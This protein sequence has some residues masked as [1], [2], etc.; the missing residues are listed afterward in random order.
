M[1][2]GITK[3]IIGNTSVTEKYEM[4]SYDDIL[5]ITSATITLAVPGDIFTN[6]GNDTVFIVDS[7]IS[8]ENSCALYLG[9]GNDIL[10]IQNSTLNTEI[11]AGSGSDTVSIV[12]NAQSYVNINNN[13]NLGEGD[14]I[15]EVASSL[16]GTGNLVFGN[17]YD[18][19]RFNGGILSLSGNIM[20]LENIETTADGGSIACDLYFDGN[21][22]NV[23]LAGNINGTTNQRKLFWSNATI[24]LTTGSNISTNVA[25]DISNSTLDHTDG[26]SLEFK[27]VGNYAITAD[28]S[29]IS[30]H[31]VTFSQSGTGGIFANGVTLSLTHAGFSN[32]QI[33]ISQTDGTL[34][35]E[36][37]SLTNHSLQALDLQ[38]TDLTGA[39][40]SFSGNQIAIQTNADIN[41]TSAKIN[42]NATGVCQS[43]GNGTFISAGLSQNTAGAIHHTGGTLYLVSGKA[44]KNTANCSSN[45]TVKTSFDGYSSHCTG[46]IYEYA[47][48]GV[49]QKNGGTLILT[50]I[51]LNNNSANVKTDLFLSSNIYYNTY[52]T[53]YSYVVGYTS[54]WDTW[55]YYS[56]KNTTY[57]TSSFVTRPVYRNGSSTY[58]TCM[59]R[60]FS[61]FAFGGAGYQNGGEC[62]IQDAT[63]AQ[64]TAVANITRS[65]TT[66]GTG[67]AKAYGGAFY[68][69]GQQ[70][71]VTSATFTE[72]T[73]RTCL[74]MV[75]PATRTVRTRVGPSPRQ[76]MKRIS[77]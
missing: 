59:I 28:N 50:D 15:L 10:S 45:N 56:G 20:G 1:S 26:G 3:N 55:L 7:T 72:N 52:W 58:S 68:F 4:S 44:Y 18:I 70:M 38:N 74:C 60:M 66:G 39:D 76:I 29:T 54:H 23:T 5:N 30:L 9:Q 16:N 51:E 6:E 24:S 32:S 73:A 35:L 46:T 17:G 71:D 69:S 14:D 13:L 63:I 8:G 57:Y 2:T 42:S 48:G 53:F 34:S 49:I 41:F 77:L 27:N 62:I 43:G 40:V 25:W 36:H 65:K 47:Q 75:F 12:G 37:S 61:A 22:N 11:F 67:I 31:N 19:L 21:E 64:N 33:G